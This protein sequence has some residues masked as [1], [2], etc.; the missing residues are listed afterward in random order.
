MTTWLRRRDTGRIVFVVPLVTCTLGLLAAGAILSRESTQARQRDLRAANQVATALAQAASATIE[1]LRGASAMVADDAVV[2]PAE[3]TSFGSEMERAADL[4]AVAV[5]VVVDDADRADFEAERGYEISDIGPDGDLVRAPQ[6]PSYAPVVAVQSSAGITPAYGFDVLG[7]PVR[8]EA[9]RTADASGVPSLSA[10]VEFFRTQRTGYLAAT[11]LR[12]PDGEVVGYVT[13]S[14]A[15][16]DVLGAARAAVDPATAV[17]VID[18]GAVVAGAADT[19]MVRAIDIGGRT[20]EVRA[21]EPTR[22]NVWPAL[23]VALGAVLASVALAVAISRLRRSERAASQL[24]A[25]LDD[26]RTRALRLADLGRDLTAAG[27]REEVVALLTDRIP[28]ITGA[29]EVT[30]AF[31]DGALLRTAGGTGLV[32]LDTHLPAT[33]AVRSSRVVTVV[34]VGEYQRAHPDLLADAKSRRVRSAAAI[35]LVTTRGTSFGVVD[36]VWEDPHTFTTG[37]EGR[38]AMLGALAAGTVQRVDGTAA[39]MRHADSLARLAEELALASTIDQVASASASHLPAISDAAAVRLELSGASSDT[40]ERHVLT[41]TSGGAVGELVVAWP[42]AAGPDAEQQERLR[43]AIG[44]IEETV[45][46][47]DI[48]RSTSEAL[49]SLRQRLLRP[50]PSP[51]GLDLAARYRPTS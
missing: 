44:L 27:T 48:Q 2:S 38:L 9:L 41:D 18:D 45:R 33:E 5:A 21:D 39:A 3:L 30:V 32:P 13:G 23:A 40:G 6:R 37:D 12:R 17:A 36:M 34:D 20:I 26:E 16:D 29:D 43:A 25:R 10:P 31:V 42:G 1:G 4:R 49:L 14:F 51:L 8:S 11:A 22:V 28:A 19:G 15:I 47:V 46:R 35:P 7:D 50:L 24:A